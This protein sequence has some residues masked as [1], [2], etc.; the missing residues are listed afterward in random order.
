MQQRYKH[1]HVSPLRSMNI[2][3]HTLFIMD[4]GTMALL[5]NGD[6]ERNDL[7]NGIQLTADEAYRLLVALQDQLSVRSN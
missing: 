6:Q 7:D 5:V 2:G 1:E 3:R 4:D